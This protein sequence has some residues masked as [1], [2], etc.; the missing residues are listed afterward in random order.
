MPVGHR[1][2][3]YRGFRF[4]IELDG[5]EVG[6]F[7]EVS[8]LHHQIETEDYAEG[9]VNGYVHKLPKAAK[10]PNLILK[11]GLTDADNLWKWQRSVG[12]KQSQIERKS[13]G[14]TLLDEEGRAKITWRCKQAYPVKWTG[15]DCKGDANTVALESLELA[16]CGIE[17]E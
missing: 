11:R 12:K 9:G 7:S 3:P 14:V 16:H 10:Q 4:R 8:G 5:V 15:P 6:G 1:T 17:R 2:D 13:V